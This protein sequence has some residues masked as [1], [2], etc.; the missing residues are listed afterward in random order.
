VS[1][2]AAKRAF[3]VAVALVALLVLAPVFLLVALAVKLDSRGPV[4][5]RQE[6]VGRA[7]RRFRIIKFRTMTVE[8]GRRAA[9]VCVGADRRV[10]RVGA[11]LRRCFLDEA[12]QLLNVL[13]GD[14]S[15]VGPRPETPEYAA[16]L[17]PAERAVLTVRPGMAGPST[18]VYS[19]SEADLLAAHD[20]PERFYREHLL[21]ARIA[22]DLRYLTD[23]GLAEDLRIL[24]RTARMVV[25]GFRGQG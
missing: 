14:M 12:P 11:V 18:L 25:S 5:F 13:V 16:L 23:G 17:T 22:A 7:G 4:F 19:A 20:D 21:H 1:G 2:Q 8:S 6:R 10:T 3:D 15:L 24:A 9:A